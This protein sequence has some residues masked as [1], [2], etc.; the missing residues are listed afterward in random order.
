MPR[1]L[2]MLPT[3]NEAENIGTLIDALLA[4]G[5][6]LEVLVV[7]DN[8]P[9]GTWRI[10]ADRAREDRRIH[11][12]HRKTARGRGLAGIAGFLEALHLGA[13]AVIEMD[14]DW[15][16]DPQYIPAMIEQ[17]KA[18]PAADVVIGSRLVA[19]GGEEGRGVTRRWI[20]KLANAYIRLMLRLPVKDATSGFRLFSRHC[21]E[22]LPWESMRATGP[23]TVQE[24]LLAADS[25]QFRIVEIP[26][27]FKDRLHGESTFNARIMVRSLLSM[28]RLRW[29]P[30][31]LVSSDD[32][33]GRYK[34]DGT[35]TFV[36]L[37]P[38]LVAPLSW[39]YGMVRCFHRFLADVGLRRR[40][41]L[42]APVVCVGNLTVG[43]TGKTPFVRMV[44]NQLMEMGRKPAIISRGYH[45]KERLSRPLVVSDG[46][47]VKASIEQSGDEPMW[48][49]RHCPGVSVVTHSKRY[50]AGKVAIK[51]LGADVVVMDD[52]FQHDVLERDLNLV[53]WDLNDLP[54]K[55][56]RLP[57]GRL[58]EGLGALKRAG[59][60][61][62]THGE[63]LPESG[64]EKRTSQVISQLKRHAPEVPIFE[65]ATR[66]VGFQTIRG[67]DTTHGQPWP[68]TGRKVIAV[69]GLARPHGFE[70]LLR[71]SGAQIA[72]H[73]AYPDH[74][75][76]M[77]EEAEQWRS[78]LER[79]GAEMILT[80]AKDSVKLD[81]IPIFGM[82]VLSVEIAME[83]T[84]PER[85]QSFLR[86]GLNL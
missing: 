38:F 84:E 8:S 52:G 82:H 23:E 78:A 48:L 30:G 53:L 50:R 45:A 28:A 25:R 69:S 4:L 26:I 73:F 79:H 31:H 59:A 47:E 16:H 17:F 22:V 64:R 39:L 57:A 46:R 54:T 13:D 63:Y 5:P 80:T 35:E 74:H 56:R 12:L 41:H 32:R 27:L 3:Y 67:R 20:T 75:L 34:G 58:R 55:A 24:I 18:E 33:L 71:D 1:I 2:A 85:W 61:V 10:V 70:A 21:L 42:K 49:A 51:Q 11:L 72:H 6:E 15:S 68:W 81:G 62:L 29:Q 65:A 76:Y 14:A 86:Q 44:S 40:R 37:P 77:G 60:I 19:G 83:I 9:D 66:I 36:P 7:D 43:G